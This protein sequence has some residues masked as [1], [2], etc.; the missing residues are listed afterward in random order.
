MLSSLCSKHILVRFLSGRSV[1]DV[2]DPKFTVCI[3]AACSPS[4]SMSFP[5]TGMK[6]WQWMIEPHPLTPATGG[7]HSCN[8]PAGTRSVFSV[9]HEHLELH[10]SPLRYLQLH[11]TQQLWG[12]EGKLFCLRLCLHQPTTMMLSVKRWALFRILRSF[13]Q[14]GI[15]FLS[16]SKVNI[17]RFPW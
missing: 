4:H 16:S 1:W 5:S 11:G 13:N 10:S 3:L 8:S 14:P 15:I 12:N 2:D 17:F 6:T 7:P 9:Q